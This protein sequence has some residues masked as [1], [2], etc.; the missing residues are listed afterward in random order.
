MWASLFDVKGLLEWISQRRNRDR[1]NCIHLDTEDEP[2][3]TLYDFAQLMLTRTSTD[4]AP[5]LIDIED[6]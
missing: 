6:E 3:D 1:I 5:W 2:H 4:Q